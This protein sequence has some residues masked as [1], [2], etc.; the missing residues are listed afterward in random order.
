[1]STVNNT[2]GIAVVEVQS[3]R[4]INYTF[5][6]KLY[7]SLNW[8]IEDAFINGST[9]NYRKNLCML[10]IHDF[11]PIWLTFSWYLLHSGK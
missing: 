8:F 1:M 7:M 3:L 11:Q 6:E 10:D 4:N 2:K 5:T 9:E